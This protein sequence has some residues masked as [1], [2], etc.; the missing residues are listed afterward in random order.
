[1]AQQ[2]VPIGS[3]VDL[4]AAGVDRTIS[5]TTKQSQS[6]NRLASLVYYPLS[7]RIHEPIRAPR[8]ISSAGQ[9][10][11][12]GSSSR[13]L[14]VP[15]ISNPFDPT[16]FSKLHV[17]LSAPIYALPCQVGIMCLIVAGK[18]RVKVKTP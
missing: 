6:T 12:E 1:M 16:Q 10:F 18:E 11:A 15:D 5:V 4:S 14:F 17:A 8:S 13:E 9:A 3:V 2:A 7:G